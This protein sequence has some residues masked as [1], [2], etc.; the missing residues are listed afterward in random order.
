MFPLEILIVPMLIFGVL[1]L[2]TAICSLSERSIALFGIGLIS[3]AACVFSSYH[4]CSGL[5]EQDKLS[6]VS[7][8]EVETTKS[9]LAFVNLDGSLKN[10][11]SI[12]SKNFKEGDVLNVRHYPEHQYG[13]FYVSEWEVLEEAEVMLESLPISTEEE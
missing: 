7:S 1:F 5:A 9:G 2:A 4:F 3:L 11:N 8:I 10:V 6:T 12:F 13:A